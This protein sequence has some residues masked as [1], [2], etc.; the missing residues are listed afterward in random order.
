MPAASGGQ[1]FLTDTSFYVALML[2]AFAILFGTR[3][4]DNT[5]RHEGLVA[6][7]AFESVVKLLAFLLVGIF[8]TYGLFDGFSDVFQ[9][10]AADPELARLMGFEAMPGRLR[11]LVISDFSV[12][13]GLFV[14]AAT[15]PDPGDRERQR[16]PYPQGHLVVSSLSVGD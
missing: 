10:A 14:S 12:H 9:R 11:G 8:V 4:I 7:V 1:P 5:E 3:H 16:G 2:I 13:D 6:A 15:V